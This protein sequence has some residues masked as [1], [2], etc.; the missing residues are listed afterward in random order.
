MELTLY[1]WGHLGG[2][3]GNLGD[4]A[5]LETQLYHLSSHNFE[6]INIFSTDIEYTKNRISKFLNCDLNRINILRFPLINPYNFFKTIRLMKNSDVLIIGGG[7]II[8]DESSRVYSILNL[9][10]CLFTKAILFGV[11]ATENSYTKTTE[12]LLDLISKNIL[13][14]FTRDEKSS[15]ILSK[16]FDK[17]SI[18]SGTDIVF[19]HPYLNNVRNISRNDTVAIIPRLPY[20]KSKIGVINYIPFKIRR[21]FFGRKEHGLIKEKYFKI[22][23]DMINYLISE[24]KIK[25]I[26]IIPFS[27]KMG[28]DDSI[29]SD[30]KKYLIERVNLGEN[31]IEIKKIKEIDDLIEILSSVSFSIPSTYHGVI[32]SVLCHVK[33]FAVSYSNKVNEIC[34]DMSIEYID[35]R[36]RDIDKYEDDQKEKEEY[37]F[38]VSNNIEEHKQKIKK[39]YEMLYDMIW[40]K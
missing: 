20:S 19:A 23:T 16:F 36:D 6:K 26:V 12:L 17:K 34:K 29:S 33:S 39:Q 38:L 22:I 9:Y 10:P 15:V 25:N 21:Y 37:T 18:Y 8:Y 35:I 3:E 7:E 40:S 24:N 28:I 31:D 13:Q 11:G 2:A 30:L 1:N 5:M 27:T 32:T 14:V 4:K